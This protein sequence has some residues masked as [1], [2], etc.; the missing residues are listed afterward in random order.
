MP[1]RKTRCCRRRRARR[2]KKYTLLTDVKH[3]TKV[4]TQMFGF[5]VVVSLLLINVFTLQPK[6]SAWCVRTGLLVLAFCNC[7]IATFELLKLW[8]RARPPDRRRFGPVTTSVIVCASIS[9]ALVGFYSMC[10]DPVP[11][12]RV[13]GASM[14]P[15]LNTNDLLIVSTDI[16]TLKVG[17]IAVYYNNVCK[18]YIAHRVVDMQYGSRLGAP[19]NKRAGELFVRLKGDSNDGYDTYIFENYFG[20]WVPLSA[21]R[22]KVIGHIPLSKIVP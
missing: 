20:S 16:T 5:W 2:V 7:T 15:M 17:D 21:I 1:P 13:V 8:E 18:C 4:I 9:A 10:G 12:F 14:S 3:A 22:Y 19:Y 6:D 11:F